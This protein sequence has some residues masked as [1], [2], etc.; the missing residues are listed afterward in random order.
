[1]YCCLLWTA[2]L[3]LYWFGFTRKPLTALHKISLTS[4]ILVKQIINSLKV[5]T[6]LHRFQIKSI[7]KIFISYNWSHSYSCNVTI[8][9]FI[10]VMT[11]NLWIYVIRLLY[12]VSYDKSYLC[13]NYDDEWIKI[14]TEC[15]C[16]KYFGC[17]MVGKLGTDVILD[18]M[19]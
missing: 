15:N 12:I 6:L 7:T 14:D 13:Y 2:Y 10:V 18:L 17:E 19:W 8:D 11:T 1:M 16:W 3:M 4:T 9:E 5:A